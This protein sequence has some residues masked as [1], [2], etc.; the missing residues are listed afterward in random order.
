MSD[1]VLVE[2]EEPIAVALLNR[3]ASAAS[4]T[5]EFADVGLSGGQVAIRD[6]WQRADLGSFSGN[7]TATSV[8]SHGVVML[9]LSQ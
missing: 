9:R 1:L 2:R 5:V 3:N 7:Y 4:I 6:L 8:P